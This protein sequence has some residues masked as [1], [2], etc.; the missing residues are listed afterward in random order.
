MN[1]YCTATSASRQRDPFIARRMIRDSAR[2]DFHQ[3]DSVKVDEVCSQG[4][5]SA[6]PH[7]T[8]HYGRKRVEE[9]AGVNDIERT[10]QKLTPRPE[11]P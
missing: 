8:S 10:R 11:L 9:H 2:V 3:G 4:C 6:S 7:L 1:T 5:T